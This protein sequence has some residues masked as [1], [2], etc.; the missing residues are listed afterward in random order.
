MLAELE[1]K[2]PQ[3]HLM[4]IG[5]GVD[6]T[7]VEF[8]IQKKQCANITVLNPILKSE[9]PRYISLIDIALVPLRNKPAYAKVIPSKIFELGAMHK[10]VLLGVNGETKLIIEKYGV[11]S[12]FKPENKS[13]FFK[14]L[15]DVLS[16]KLYQK[17]SQNNF[18]RFCSDFSRNVQAK[19][20]QTVLDNM[21]I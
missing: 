9:V 17:V 15:E 1:K 20:M 8:L 10:Y 11:G 14:V 21:I 4:F 18:N 7:T 13:S 12:Y 19:K 3:L 16:N 5:D 2:H 6:K